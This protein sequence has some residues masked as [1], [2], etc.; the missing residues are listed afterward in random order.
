[1]KKSI[2]KPD[3][4][5][6]RDLVKRTT[7]IK[8]SLPS[9]SKKEEAQSSIHIHTKPSLPP[10]NEAI[11]TLPN[12]REQ[13]KQF[14]G[15]KDTDR[16]VLKHM[17]DRQLLKVC[18][19]DKRMWIEVCDDSFLK[20]RLEKYPDIE[21]YKKEKESWKQF[22]LRAVHIIAKMQEEFGFEYNTGNFEKQYELFKKYKDFDLLYNASKRGELSLIKFAVSHGVSLTDEYGIDKP[23]GAAANKGHLDI[24][25]YLLE[26][27]YNIHEGDD[28]AL[29][30]ASETGHL[31]I[32]KYLVEHDARI[33][34][35][36]I[37]WAQE[38]GH[39]KVVKYLKSKIK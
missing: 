11:K 5:E 25:K 36:A 15:L 16:E 31:E 6:F 27:G 38:A 33:S 8:L 17:D 3:S 26:K 9:L 37:K 13:R 21:K 39:Q 14:T 24:V 4:P 7:N 10:L 23:L 18:S 1:M 20:R 22:F 2:F 12:I 32:V 30:I 19:I 34:N 35:K 29:K 28:Y